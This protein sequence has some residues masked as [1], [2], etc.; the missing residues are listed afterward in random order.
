MLKTF[1]ESKKNIDHCLRDMKIRQITLFTLENNENQTAIQLRRP[2]SFK[3][4]E[5]RYSNDFV[6]YTKI[7]V[8]SQIVA[9]SYHK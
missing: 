9:K 7:W 3:L 2:M 1:L 5:N 4:K 6:I 8:T